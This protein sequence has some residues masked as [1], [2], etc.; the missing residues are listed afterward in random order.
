MKTKSNVINN[1]GKID[2]HV[3]VLCEQIEQINQFENLGSAISSDGG[4]GNAMNPRRVH[5]EF[6]KAHAL[7]RQEDP[8]YQ[9][10]WS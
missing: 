10:F 1:K 2:V 7:M 3:D 4:A 6:P 5:W 9:M 8:Y